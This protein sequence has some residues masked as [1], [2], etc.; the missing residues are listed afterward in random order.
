MANIPSFEEGP[1][2]PIKQM[3]RYISIGGAGEVRHK[4]QVCLTSPAAPMFLR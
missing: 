4:R 2:T 1:P 3:E